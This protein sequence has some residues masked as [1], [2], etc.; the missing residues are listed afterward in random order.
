MPFGLT[1][2]PV[3]FQRRLDVVISCLQL[4]TCLVYIYNILIIFDE[5]DDDLHLENIYRNE[6]V[7]FIEHDF[8]VSDELPG[9]EEWKHKHVKKIRIE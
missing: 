2:Y 4:K 6:T 9:A 3:T 7:N 5:I 1:N 8:E